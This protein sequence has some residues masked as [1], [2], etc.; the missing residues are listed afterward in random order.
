MQDR[1]EP[2]SA[3]PAAPSASRRTL[4]RGLG[5]AVAAPWLAVG[6]DAAQT[7]TN[8]LGIAVADPFVLREPN[9]QY[10][11]YGTGG[12]R[13]TTA[14]PAF[15]STDVVHWKPIGEVYSRDPATAWCTDTFW[16]PAVYHVK[17]RYYLFYSAQWRENPNKEKENYRIGAAVSDKPEGPFRDIRNAPLFDP[18]YP[19]ID[20]EL[21]FDTDGRIYLFYSRCC[22]KHPVESEL[23]DWA[24]K[25]NI[26]TEIEESWIYGVE[27]KPD[28]TGTIGEP[29]MALRP[30]V[31]LSDKNAAWENLSVTTKEV[32]R[33]WTEGPCAFKHNG[34][35]YLMYS[36]NHYLGENYALG[37]ATAKHPLG[38]YTKAANNPV[39]KKNTDRGGNV[40]GPA[41][42][43][44]TY[45]P[46]GSEMLC[47]YAGRTAA[48]GQR[49]VLFLDRMEIHKD[50]TL[51]VHGPV[52]TPQPLPSSRKRKG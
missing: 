20:A 24:R 13:G 47:L 3:A 52:T 34:T 8:P 33:R 40:T 39:L 9:G 28:F 26:Y 45:S 41:H 19:A 21:L 42:N 48:T 17:D 38:P 44:V 22:Y 1:N 15:T 29:V 35:Y 7:Y 25:E 10:F 50:G 23:A 36:A 18:G 32:N 5:A 43:C 12:G 46:D 49:R 6:Q 27:V 2:D 11:V 31:S 4:L 37:Y 14:Y 16:A 51:V 30:P